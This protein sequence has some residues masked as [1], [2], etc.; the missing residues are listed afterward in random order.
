MAK[1]P[2]VGA[3]LKAA[4]VAAAAAAP[5]PVVAIV[6]AIVLALLPIGAGFAVVGGIALGAGQSLSVLPTNCKAPFNIF[7][8]WDTFEDFVTGVDCSQQCAVSDIGGGGAEEGIG[9]VEKAEYVQTIIGVG[10][11]MNV[12]EKGILAALATTIQE[13]GIKNYA[14]DG[15]YNTAKNP[16]DA[17]LGDKATPILEF[18]KKSLSFPHDAVG[19]DATSVG[20][21]QQQAWWGT[22]GGSTWETDPNGTI[23][24]L[25]D[26]TFQAQ[27][28]YNSLLAVPNWETMGVGQM[29]QK[30]QVSAFPD[31]YNLRVPEAQALY[32]QHK[33]N[34]KEVT[35]YDFGKDYT[36]GGA[37][38]GA[39]GGGS[40]G[41]STSSSTGIVLEKSSLYQVTAQWSQP[42]GAELLG[43][44]NGMDIDC[45]DDYEDVFTPV[46]GVVTLAVNGNPSGQGEPAGYVMVKTDDGT[47][48][49]LWHMRNVFVKGGDTVE[50]GQAV[51]ECASTGLSFG[52]HLHIETDISKTTN[53]QIKALPTSQWIGPEANRR[54]PALVLEILGVDICPPYVANRK[55]AE[56]GSMLP[57][58]GILK[59]WPPEE[60]TK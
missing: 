55:T 5:I 3:A 54:D 33:G 4:P 57:L 37:E 49:W 42:R 47:I 19:S 31:A 20:L 51:G 2:D 35:L 46:S 44:H 60:W 58:G 16:A 50:G 14:N 43:A 40:C 36:G 1:M 27:K 38:E 15:V 56:P 39:G 32:S 30:V 21:F 17:T 13:S 9:S 41:G 7:D 6:V 12:P 29:A 59:C 48:V 22:M 52:T 18:S 24:R 10:K 11:A 53:E 34:A 45:G 23:K 25:M 8:A 28:F 26:P